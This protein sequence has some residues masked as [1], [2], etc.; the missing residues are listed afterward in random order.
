MDKG[1]KIQKL[2]TNIDHLGNNTSVKLAADLSLVPVWDPAIP[3]PTPEEMCDLN[4]VTHVVAQRAQPDGYHYLHEATVAF[5]RNKFYLGWANHLTGETGDHDELI[6][7]CT[8]DNALHWGEPTIWAQA[9]L[10]G[11]SSHNHPL[12]FSHND[13]LYGFFVCWREE[14][15]PTTEIFIFNDCTNKWEH[16]KESAIYGFLPFCTPQRMANGNWIIGGEHHWYDAAVAISDGDDFTKWH[17]I[18]ITRSDDFKLL[19]PETSIVNYGNNHLLAICR[20]SREMLTAPVSESHDGGLTW[21]PLAMSNLPLSDSQPFAGRLSTGHNYLLF[22]HLE[23]GR[24]LLTIAVTGP[25]G[26]LFRRIFK[27]RHQKYPLRR[28]YENYVGM[29]TEWS[30]PNAF[31][32]NGCLYIA[33][34]QGKEDCVLSIVPIES[35]IV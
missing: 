7:G 35:L 11:A 15:Y 32:Y 24:A 20:P 33:Y 21:T 16:Q 13:K 12:I 8:S 26:G 3:F 17:M 31:E 28:H 29:P 30:Y 4:I 18:D 6:R 14:H 23:E 25:K 1:K 34:S 5:H 9:P 27:L 2:I 10:L 22:N 19:F